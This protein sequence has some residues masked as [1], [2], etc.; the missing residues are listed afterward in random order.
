M[1]TSII[2]PVNRSLDMLTVLSRSEINV[3]RYEVFLS[4]CPNVLIYSFPS[5]LD[6]I[7]KFTQSELYFLIEIQEEVYVSALPFCLYHG[8][9]GPVI[10]SL[11]F[12]GSNGG[13]LRTQASKISSL[14]LTTALLDFSKYKK[15]ISVTVIESPLTPEDS[16]AYNEFEY[17]DYRVSLI[18]HFDELGADSELLDTFED[19]RPR[20][21]RRAIKAGVEVRESQTEE[22]LKFLAETHWE[23]ITAVGGLPKTAEFFN[24]FLREMPSDE[25][26]I[27]EA[28]LAGKR[29]ASL[30]MLNSKSTTEY[31]TPATLP[32]YRNLQALPL[33][34]YRGM[35]RSIRMGHLSWNW[36]GTWESQKGV[37]DFKRKF[38]PKETRYN[39]Y[40]TIFDRTILSRD[41]EFF[42]E[43]Y[44]N[45]YIMPFA[46]L[47][48]E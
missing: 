22:S 13:S 23:N 40:C 14:E 2:K 10:N 9:L 3:K 12:Y 28:A 16:S 47:E 18:N 34:I 37:Y 46:L 6:M 4:E 17:R 26:T 7:S 24:F 39:Y 27:L 20:N 25:W 31:F 8:P 5:Y 11:P 29:I 33:L 41:K 48:R 30:L 15:C 38:R 19:P 21:I 45:F 42:V 43:K 35:Q 44:P 1:V 32:E 36:G